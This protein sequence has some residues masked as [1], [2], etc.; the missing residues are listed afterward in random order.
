MLTLSSLNYGLVVAH[1]DAKNRIY[2]LNN[3]KALSA[4]SRVPLRLILFKRDLRQRLLLVK[5]RMDVILP[6]SILV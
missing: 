3:Q 1:F 5:R 2:Q 6:L 4:S